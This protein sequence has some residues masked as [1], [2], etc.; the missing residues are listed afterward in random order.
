MYSKSISFSIKLVVAIDVASAI[1]FGAQP[2]S[3]ASFHLNAHK[4]HLSP[5]FKPGKPNCGT[6]LVK[7]FPFDFEYCKNSLVRIAHLFAFLSFVI[8]I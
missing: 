5:S 6:A 4:H 3:Y 8:S 2:A 7:S 1:I